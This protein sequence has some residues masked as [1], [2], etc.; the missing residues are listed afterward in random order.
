MERHRNYRG[1]PEVVFM[2]DGSGKPAVPGGGCSTTK[3]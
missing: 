1:N 3:T 2:R